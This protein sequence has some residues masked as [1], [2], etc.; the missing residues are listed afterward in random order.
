MTLLLFSLSVQNLFKLLDQFEKLSG[1]KVN[2]TKTEAMWIGSSRDN[3]ETPLS[4]K[5]CK[6]VKALGI[7]F[8]YNKEELLQKNVDDKVS[9]IKKQIHLWSWRGLSLFGKVSIIKSL[10]LPKLTY[11]FSVFPPPLEFIKLTQTI[12]YKFLWKGPDKITRGAA[13]NNLDYGGLNL[14][15]L[16]TSMKSLRLAWISRIFNTASASP[17]KSYLEYL[18]RPFGGTF[19]L[20]CNY[21]INDYNF[22]SVFYSE[23]LQWWS[24]F[25]SKFA[26][27]TTPFNSIIWNN[28]NIRLEGNPIYYKNYVTAGVIFVRDLM[29]HLNN[30]ESFNLAKAVGLTGTN[31]LI[32][33]GVRCSVPK[34]LRDQDTNRNSLE[35]LEFKYANKSFN[36]T[37]SKSKDFYA[38][39]IKVKTKQSRGFTNLL[40]MFNLNDDEVRKAFILIKS[41]AVETFVQCFQ[42]KILNDILFLNSRLAKIGLITSDRCTFCNASQETIEHLFFQCTYSL[43]FWNNFEK[44]WLTVT[45][46]KKKLQYKEVIL[47]I[48]DKKTDLLNY[49][50]ILGKLYLWN[51]RK[52]NRTPIFSLFEVLVKSKY[53]TEKHIAAQNNLT[54]KKFQAKW[55]P[56]L[57]TY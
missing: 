15:D 54:L 16:E 35:S 22:N 26:T 51:C 21:N 10:L 13:I 29:F 7:H 9:D 5:W 12:I 37:L 38:L 31:Y 6:T 56:F 14:T 27:E 24:E 44:Y 1:L 2:Y 8:S 42:F 33:T 47:G 45:K 43:M 48:L 40:S 50:I 23:M 3:T 4:L 52:N 39:L 36:P 28:C 53:N 11:I 18:L 55:K 25:R 46:E 30:I 17:W 49:L 57:H 19:F 41:V 32:W 34:E 20:H